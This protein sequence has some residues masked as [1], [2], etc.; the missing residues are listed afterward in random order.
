VSEGGS[1]VSKRREP[2]FEEETFL[3]LAFLG[4]PLVGDGF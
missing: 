2:F 3:P 4:D 1:F